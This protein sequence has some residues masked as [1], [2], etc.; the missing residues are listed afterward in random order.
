MGVN[1]WVRFDRDALSLS[2]ADTVILM[3]GINDIGWL[4][5]GLAPHEMAPSADDI[6]DGYK[7]LIAG[8][9]VHG[10]RI[11]VATLTPFEDAFKGTRKLASK[12]LLFS[13][14]SGQYPISRT[15]LAM[16]SLL[17]RERSTPTAS[18]AS[19]EDSTARGRNENNQAADDE[20]PELGSPET[21][22]VGKGYR[23]RSSIHE[24]GPSIR[25]FDRGRACA[26]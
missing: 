9:H 18:P 26:Y 25:K 24:N 13:R 7:Q 8:A 23:Y 10:M 4:G 17:S 2:H 19:T 21:L 22:I 20:V 6:I 16:N 3:L 5:S 1:A 15:H 14:R 11:I 12:C